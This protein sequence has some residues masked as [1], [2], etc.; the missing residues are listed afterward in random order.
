LTGAQVVKALCKASF[1]VERQRSSHIYLKHTDGRATVVPVHKGESIG[2]GLLRKI[3]RD[4]E[5]D[6]DEF[7]ALL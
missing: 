2:K 5:M 7:L 6:K 1:A 4:T 3:I